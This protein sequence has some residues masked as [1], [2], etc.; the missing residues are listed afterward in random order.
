M[1]A[2]LDELRKRLN[3]ERERLGKGLEQLRATAPAMGETREG[4]PYGKKEEGAAE[5]FELEKRLALEKRL[6]EFL[7]E[8]EH[9]LHK[10]ALG[11]YGLC[12]VCGQTIG[13]ERLEV[14]PQANLCLACKTRQARNAKGKFP[15]R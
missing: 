10:M 7:G 4:S 13:M 6:T 11:T 14:L 9:A 8:V 15:S 2:T 1:P 3:E 5:T 12:D